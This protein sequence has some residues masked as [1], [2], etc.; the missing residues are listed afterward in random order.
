MFRYRY[1]YHFDLIDCCNLIRNM[2]C[3]MK[4]IIQLSLLTSLLWLI[5]YNSRAQD[6]FKPTTKSFTFGVSGGNTGFDPT[7]GIE[8]GTP[9]FSKERFCVRIKAN[10]SWLERFKADFD[11]WVSYHSFGISFIYNTQVVDRSR[12]YIDMGANLI[13]PN[14]KFATN[15]NI[16]AISG[17]AGVELFIFTKPDLNVSYY[18]GG[19]FSYAQAYADKMENKPRYSNGV[20]FNNGLRFYFKKH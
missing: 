11:N 19:G 10:I 5:S 3:S 6:T 12:F 2:V 18:F 17:L 13:V 7:L 20:V 8:I 16:E 1:H 14:A 9:T 15:K 4:H